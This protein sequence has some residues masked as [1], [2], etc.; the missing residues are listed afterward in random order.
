M[1]ERIAAPR[2]HR[3]RKRLKRL[4]YLAEFTARLHDK[5]AFK[6]Y[7]AKLKKVQDAL[8]DYNDDMTALA[9]Y[10]DRARGDAQAW[11][12]VAWLQAEREELARDCGRRLR[13][14]AKADPFW[15]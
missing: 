13:K 14:L 1:F 2:Q 15:R 3:V 9:Y 4:R 10:R 5:K 12:A 6:S 11:F 8:G 7:L